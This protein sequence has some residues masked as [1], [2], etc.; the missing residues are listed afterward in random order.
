MQSHRRTYLKIKFLAVSLFLTLLT[1]PLLTLM[2]QHDSGRDSIIQLSKK[3]FGKA[4]AMAKQLIK[5]KRNSAITEEESL[6]LLSMIACSKNEIPA[7]LDYAKQALAKGM[8][9]DRYQVFQNDVFA[10]LFKNKEFAA[11]ATGKA[12]TL[13]HGPMLGQVTGT[14]ASFWLRT[15]GENKLQI[16]VVSASRKSEVFMSDKKNTKSKNDHTAICRVKGLS[17]NSE[18]QYQVIIDGKKLDKVYSFNTFID[19][20]KSGQFT[21]AFGGGSGFTPKNERAWSVISQHKPDATLLLG[22]NVYIDDPTHTLTQRYCYYRR[23]SQPD[24]K[25]FISQTSIYSIY[26]DHDF[27]TNDCVPGPDIENPSWKRA[28]WETFRQNWNNPFYA[29]GSEQPGCWFDFMIGD[30]H[31][32]M[33][34]GRY[35]RDLKGKSMLG[36]VQKKWLFDTLKKSTGTFKLLIS[37]VPW[38]PGVKGGSRDTWDGFP[39]EREQIFDLIDKEKINGLML[40]SADRHRSD[41]RRIKRKSGYDL[42]EMMSSRLTNVHVH[43]LLQNAKGSEFIFGYNKKCSFGLLKIDSAAKEPSLTYEIR[44]IDNEKIFSKKFILKELTHP[45]K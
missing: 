28:V 38:S 5:N 27:A 44:S 9:I 26:D 34:D 8:T 4:E 29:G 6:Y 12:K 21:I 11:I 14:E 39:E 42:Y 36:S 7:S 30:V 33:L 19:Q 3:E 45:N 20:G 2:A 1:S 43:P 37:P 24:W 41:L 15:S 13:L 22:D 10:P 18:Y 25:N 32:I 23:H 40:V 16:E 35:Y 31:F 17:A